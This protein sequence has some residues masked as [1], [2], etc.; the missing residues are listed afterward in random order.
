MSGQSLEKTKAWALGILEPLRVNYSADLLGR[1]VD[2]LLLHDRGEGRSVVPM[3]G[4]SDE[5]RGCVG[6]CALV[7][8]AEIN[9]KRGT[10]NPVSFVKLRD[11]L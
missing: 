5:M 4:L 3:E 9:R 8:Q 7:L 11:V 2:H 10:D 6:V 1:A